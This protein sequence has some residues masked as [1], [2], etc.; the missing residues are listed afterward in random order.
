MLDD[1][2]MA[3]VVEDIPEQEGPNSRMCKLRRRDLPTDTPGRLKGKTFQLAP[4]LWRS[5]PSSE[6]LLIPRRMDGMPGRQSIKSVV[7]HTDCRGTTRLG[8]ASY[9]GTFACVFRVAESVLRSVAGTFSACPQHAGDFA[10]GRPRH[11]ALA[12]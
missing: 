12:R 10:C 5:K 1:V 9:L 8:T 3:A 11:L 7:I 6:R 2:L 4:G